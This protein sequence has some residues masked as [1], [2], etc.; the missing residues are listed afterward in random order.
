VPYD[1]SR[2]IALAVRKELP[3][4]LARPRVIFRN[5]CSALDCL[6]AEPKPTVDV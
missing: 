6:G 1:I 3:F 5:P 2:L 4:R